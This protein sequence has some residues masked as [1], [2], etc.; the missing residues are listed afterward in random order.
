M[1]KPG[2]AQGTSAFILQERQQEGPGPE[3]HSGTCMQMST[4]EVQIV[5]FESSAE[6]L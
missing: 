3:G 2:T 5:Y 4:R 1:H 6:N